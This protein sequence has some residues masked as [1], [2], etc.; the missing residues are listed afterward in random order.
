MKIDYSFHS[1]TSRC[2]H[3]RGTDEEYI[4]EAIKKGLKV[5]GVTDHIFF[6]DLDQPGTR[7]SYS[8]LN[9]YV[10]SILS[11]K[12]KYKDKITILLGFECEYFEKYDSYY[13]HLI[14]DLPFDYFLLGQHFL[15]KD[16]EIVYLRN[17]LDDS[18]PE[19]YIREVTKGIETGLFTYLAHPDLILTTKFSFDESAKEISYRICKLC[20]EKD[21]PIEINLNGMTWSI[22]GRLTYPVDD[23]WK[24]ASEVGNKVVI[25]YDAHWPEFY[26]ETKYMDRALSIVEKYNLILLNKE[27][28]EKRI[29]QIKSKFV[30]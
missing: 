13:H 8:Q 25:G 24:I 1:H 27:D 2:G 14:K 28:I 26:G 10:S 15:I 4:L 23:F 11:L 22:P 30:K 7:G 21:I 5:I 29:K 16:N 3:A 17:Y 9:D 6:P 20:K 18:I 12:E 19:E